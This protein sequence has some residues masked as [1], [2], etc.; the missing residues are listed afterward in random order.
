MAEILT[1]QDPAV[2][3]KFSHRT[4]T[5]LAQR[6]YSGFQSRRIMEV[7]FRRNPGMVKEEVSG[8][9]D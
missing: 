6:G 5:S 2:Y 9:N 1:V 8:G 4:I 3:L 7:S